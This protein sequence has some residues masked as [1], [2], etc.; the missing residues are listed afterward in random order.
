M[1]IGMLFVLDPENS[2]KEIWK[3]G[4]IHFGGPQ[5]E[6]QFRKND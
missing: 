6:K 4:E 5:T 2:C 1:E 3:I